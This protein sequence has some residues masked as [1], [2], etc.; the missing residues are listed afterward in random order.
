MQSLSIL[1]PAGFILITI[2]AIYIF[3]RA[4]DRSKP[5]LIILFSWALIQGLVS[6][7]GFYQNTQTTPPRIIFLLLPP[8]AVIITLFISSKGRRFI[9]QLRPDLV[10]LIHVVRFPVEI[11]LY[12]LFLNKEVPQLMTFAG[13]NYDIISGLTAPFIYYFGFVRKKIAAPF[14]LG[15]NLVCLGLLL[16][17]VRRAILSAPSPFQELAFDLPNIAIQHFP[18]TWLPAVLVPLVFFSQLVMIRKYIL[19]FRKIKAVVRLN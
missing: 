11:V 9:G 7:S 2:L 14:L 15:W 10:T 18:Y 8:I 17:I 6:F 5:I 12:G 3:Y 19:S 13:G 1:I 4:A 16:F